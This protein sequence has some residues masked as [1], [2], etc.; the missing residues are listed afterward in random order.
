MEPTGIEPATSGLQNIFKLSET[1]IFFPCFLGSEAFVAI[2]SG[3]NFFHFSKGEIPQNDT[4]ILKKNGLAVNDS[5]SKIF[6][7]FSQER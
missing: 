3:W 6:C 7:S 4:G 1:F 5:F 2:C